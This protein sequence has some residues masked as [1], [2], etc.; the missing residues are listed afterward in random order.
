VATVIRRAK[1]WGYDLADMMAKLLAFSAVPKI[2]RVHPLEGGVFR[3]KYRRDRRPRMPRESRLVFYARYASEMMVKHARFAL[4]FLQYRRILRRVMREPTVDADVA[5][6]PVQ[7]EEFTTLDMYTAAPAT[8]I[9]V[10]KLRRQSPT[11]IPATK[12][13]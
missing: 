4:L 1:A 13:P 5:M 3:R 9:A 10:E 2:E 12:V 8:R 6:T 11:R 7:E